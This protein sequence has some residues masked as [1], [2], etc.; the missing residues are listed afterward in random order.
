[1]RIE[2]CSKWVLLLAVMAGACSPEVQKERQTEGSLSGSL[3]FQSVADAYVDNRH[4]SVNYG[5]SPT[6]VSDG[7]PVRV[8]YLRFDV[9]GL[10]APVAS[11]QLSFHAIDG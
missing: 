5:T 4:P 3:E 7:N 10:T 6:L 1:M 11:A 8:A 9:T 2:A